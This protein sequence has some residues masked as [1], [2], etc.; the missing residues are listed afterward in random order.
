MKTPRRTRLASTLLFC[1]TFASSALAAR[2]AAPPKPLDGHPG[3]IFLV[4]EDV[5]V[6]LTNPAE[7][8]RLVD[9][10]NKPLASGGAGA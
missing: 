6:A 8:W 2:P 1:L 5:T 3:N 9:Y 4:G 10:D 7:P